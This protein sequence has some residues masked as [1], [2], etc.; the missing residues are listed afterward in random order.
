MALSNDPHL[1]AI[2]NNSSETTISVATTYSKD[3]TYEL[4]GANAIAPQKIGNTGP[5]YIPYYED[6]S[7]TYD[8][9]NN[10][11]TLT[12]QNDDV[13]L[14][15]WQ[16]ENGIY[17]SNVTPTSCNSSSDLLMQ[18][19]NISYDFYLTLS[20]D[21]TFAITQI[22]KSDLREN[23]KAARDEYETVIEAVKGALKQ[24]YKGENGSNGPAIISQMQSAFAN[25]S[26]SSTDFTTQMMN[27]PAFQN[28]DF[29][30]LDFGPSVTV[31]VELSGEYGLGVAGSASAAIDLDNGYGADVFTLAGTCGA[32]I[33]ASGTVQ[34]G[35]WNS[36]PA[37][38]AGLT[39]GWVLG[40][41]IEEIGG[42]ITVYFNSEGTS[43][44]QGISI[45]FGVGLDFQAAAVF[46]YSWVLTS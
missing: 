38:L 35:L 25:D 2:Y 36:A 9:K 46:G 1:V 24:F 39:L 27:D 45:G 41:E 21:N 28:I 14:Y 13:L 11:I 12:D 33:G 5:M 31:G 22:V 37:D 19:D 16:Y 20:S 40:F 4:N 3:S 6:N 15:V 26:Y 18:L 7:D 23:A 32:Q 17:G 42:S 43:T 34:V 10:H 29:S 8:F 44:L 30:E